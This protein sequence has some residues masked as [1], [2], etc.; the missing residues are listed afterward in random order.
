MNTRIFGVHLESFLPLNLGIYLVTCLPKHEDSHS[1]SNKAI[2][3]TPSFR[4]IVL[5]VPVRDIC[6]SVQ[7][8]L[9]NPV[10]RDAITIKQSVLI[11]KFKVNRV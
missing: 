7:L 5:L 8:G 2:K 11:D 10:R 9:S 6:T 3:E 1:S 4:S